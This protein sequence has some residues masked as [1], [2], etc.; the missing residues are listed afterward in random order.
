MSLVIRFLIVRNHWTEL[1]PPVDPIE[2]VEKL[3]D[4]KISNR[5]IFDDR[6]TVP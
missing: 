5:L 4:N 1:P 2:S 3:V 6:H